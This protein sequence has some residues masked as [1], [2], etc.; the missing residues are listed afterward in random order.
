MVLGLR[1]KNGLKETMTLGT[2][3]FN[4]IVN[5]IGALSVGIF[6]GLFSFLLPNT[7]QFFPIFAIFMFAIIGTTI[8]L[9]VGGIV[10]AIRLFLDYLQVKAL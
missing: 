2:L 8:L 1:L 6:A 10:G 7:F 3:L 9:S 4:V 5:A